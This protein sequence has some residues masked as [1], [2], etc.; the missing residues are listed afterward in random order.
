MKRESEWIYRCGRRR[1]SKCMRL[2]QKKTS[3]L[4]FNQE[5]PIPSWIF[6]CCVAPGT[7]GPAEH[8]AP[9]RA[10]PSAFR[11]STLLARRTVHLRLRAMRQDV[12]YA[13]RHATTR[14]DLNAI[15]HPT[16]ARPT[17]FFVKVGMGLREDTL[18]EEAREG[19]VR[20]AADG[21]AAREVGG[22]P[23]DHIRRWT[24]LQCESEMSVERM[25]ALHV[26]KYMGKHGATLHLE[27]D[28]YHFC[29]HDS[30]SRAETHR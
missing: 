28:T 11:S 9:A 17:I 23:D 25:S 18:G 26:G 24:A 1:K 16:F 5:V 29:A 4:I 14:A 27:D 22:H 2:W 30:G 3:Y 10:R 13:E 20:C 7:S 15:A 6:F 21:D 12:P 19:G 8:P